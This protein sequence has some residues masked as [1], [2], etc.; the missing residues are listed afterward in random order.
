MAASLTLLCL[1]LLFGP[2]ATPAAGQAPL[3]ISSVVMQNKV[4]H[5]VP[6]QYPEAARKK[7]IQGDVHVDVVIARNGSVK[8]AKPIDGQKDLAKA[9]V[10]AV[11]QWKYAPTELNGTTVEVETTVLLGFHLSPP[12]A[13]PAKPPSHR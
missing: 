7:G 13:K 2:A 11:K 6:P 3:R 10:K 5:M 12:P 9:A 1:S 8:S 4:T